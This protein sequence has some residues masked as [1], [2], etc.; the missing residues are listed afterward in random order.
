[1]EHSAR[2]AIALRT[3][4]GLVHV[5]N[6]RRCVQWV[7]AARAHLALGEPEEHS[8]WMAAREVFPYEAREVLRPDALS[9]SEL[10]VCVDQ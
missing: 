7:A 5:P 8:G 4:Y 3:K 1:M 9:V 2:L 6:S 10:L